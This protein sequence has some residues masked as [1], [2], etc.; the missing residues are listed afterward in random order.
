MKRT[1]TYN[2][3]VVNPSLSMEWHPSKNGNLSPNDVTPN[4]HKKVWWLCKEGHEWEAKVLNR[5][6][7]NNC[8]YCSNKKV[9]DDNCLQSLNPSLAKEWHPTKNNSLSPKDVTPNSHKLVWW[10]CNKNHEWKAIVKSRNRGNKCPYCSG[11]YVSKENCLQTLNPKLA[12]EWHPTKNGNLTPTDVTP[13]SHKK[14]WW[15]CKKDHEWIVDVASRNAGNKCPYC[16]NK[17]VCKDNCLQ[18]TNPQLVKEWHPTKNGIL[19]QKDVTAGSGKKVWWICKKGH[20]WVASIGSRN[21]GNNCP[22]CSSQKVSRDNCLQT[23]NPKL[24]KEWHPT[25][26]DN[27]TPRDVTPNS[28]K[29]IWWICKKGHVVESQC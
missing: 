10:L 13:N 1:N 2:L 18:T 29:K 11:L 3:A 9:N 21:S 19:T 27:L 20:E 8:P 26:N 15:L 28:G 24:A 25:Q 23:L 12:K 16:S 4:S 17:K 14:V 5:N 7:G 6:N 22:Y